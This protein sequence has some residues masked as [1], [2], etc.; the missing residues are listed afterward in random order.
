M[1]HE[2]DAVERARWM[3]NA[4]A[5]A[6]IGKVR[7]ELFNELADEIERLRHPKI[8]VG[9]RKVWE[10]MGLVVARSDALEAA[11]KVAEDFYPNQTYGISIAA[12]IR[13]LKEKADD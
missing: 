6:G 11:A 3:A 10:A 13:A 5:R 9:S 1:P 4:E 7:R 8:I 12:A 2:K